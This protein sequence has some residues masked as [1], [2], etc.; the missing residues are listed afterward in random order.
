VYW[1]RSFDVSY[2]LLNEGKYRPAVSVGMQDFLGTGLLS[3]EYIVATKSIG[4]RLRVTGGLGWGRLASYNPLGISFGERDTSYLETGGTFNVNQWF[5]G[6]IA[7][8]GGL[9]YEVND[10]LTFLA[11]YSSDAYAAEVEAGVFEHTSPFNFGV[12]YKL[13]KSTAVSAYY[14]HGGEVGLSF[15]ASLNPKSASLRSGSETAPL[16]VLTRP[17]RAAEP[18]GWSGAWVSEVGDGALIQKALKSAMEK[19]GLRLEAMSLDVTRVELRYSNTRYGSRA[20]A[21]GRLSRIMTRAFPPSVEKFTLTETLEGIPVH[22]TI[23]M[24]SDLERNEFK[25]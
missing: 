3:G 25:P 22:S 24:R 16:P 13:G 20:Q 6:P 2:L 19:E 9:T 18:E 7:P 4:N 1:D 8:F 17:S 12:D 10:K 15:S 23:V 11:E 21:I 14:L 5:R